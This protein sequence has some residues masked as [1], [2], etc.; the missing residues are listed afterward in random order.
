MNLPQKIVLA[1]NN[2]HKVE[3]ITQILAPA[4]DIE[5]KTL[6]D[7]PDIPEVKED[8]ETFAGNALKKALA[9]MDAA[10]LP[11]LADDSG[12]E[13]DAL[14]LAPGVRSAR[15]SG[16]GAAE[17]NRLLL[18]NMEDVEDE[19]R[20]ARF[21]CVMALCIPGRDAV[22]AEGRVEGRINRAEKGRGGFGYDPLFVPEGFTLT[23]AE[24]GSAEKNTLSHRANALKSLIKKIQV[25]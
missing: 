18:L 2:R 3:E 20:T 25:L 17:N 22:I 19:K 13:V 15:Y 23:F 8:Q 10:G 11:A 4:G 9:V 5:F 1:T 7:F 16:K 14:F 24:M 12:L 21:R 6:A